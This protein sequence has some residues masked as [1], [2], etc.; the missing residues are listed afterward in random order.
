MAAARSASAVV[1]VAA[2]A[3]TGVHARTSRLGERAAPHHQWVTTRLLACLFALSAIGCTSSGTPSPSPAVPSPDRSASAAATPSASAAQGRVV[4]FYQGSTDQRID[5]ASGV[6][7]VC[8]FTLRGTVFDYRSGVHYRIEPIAPTVGQPYF[9]QAGTDENGSWRS[10]VISLTDGDWSLTVLGAL[11]HPD[12]SYAIKVACPGGR[13]PTPSPPIA[14]LGPI[15]AAGTPTTLELFPQGR[16]TGKIAWVTKVVAGGP[17]TPGGQSG[18]ALLELWA[19]S[20]D[21]SAPRLAARYRSTQ[22]NSFGSMFDTNIL[23]RQFSPDGRRL[24]LSVST[25]AGA[26]GHGLAVIDLEAGRLATMIGGSNERELTPAW[27]PDGRLIAFIRPLVTTLASEIWIVA[28]DGSGARRLRTGTVGTSNRVFGWTADSRRIGFSPVD[29]E[30]TTYALIDLNGIESPPLRAILNSG[31]AVDWRARE[32]GFAVSTTDSPYTPTRSDIIIGTDPASASRSVADVV[33]NPSDNTVTGVRNPRWDPSGRDRL[34]Y[35]QNGIQGSFVLTDISSSNV[36]RKQAGG[37][38]AFA[39]WLADG[40]GIVTLEEHPSTAPLS[41]YV[42]DADA[43]LVASGLFLPNPNNE[44]YRL[45]DL[46][47]RSY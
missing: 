24:V 9:A 20:L 7:T 41:V 40:S 46:A 14:T 17:G 31:D 10:A 22:T 33:V 39:E 21:R 8:D 47:A 42:Y 18:S 11:T 3:A 38:A 23:R 43:K 32:P 37:R 12:Q 30:S 1:A 16:L 28:P 34:I 35:L 36:T 44:G 26:N 15:S 13:A 25:G 27:S 6:F 5:P 45:A 29:F 2:A 19:I 4:T